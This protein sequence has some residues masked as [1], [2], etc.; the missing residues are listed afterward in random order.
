MVTVLS[1]VLFRPTVI[2]AENIPTSGPLI[3][4]PTHRSNIDF[5]FS[6]FV[7]KRKV[8]FM[9][10]DSLFAVKP[11][12]WL[13]RRVGAFP[14]Q[15]GAAD[16]ESMSLAE[17][18]LKRGEALILFPEGTRQSGDTI[19]ELHDGATFIAAR[20]GASIVPIG[21]AGSEYA[22][23]GGSKRIRP[24]KIVVVVGRPIAPPASEGRVA[25]S[26]VSAMT[27]ELQRSL[28]EVFDESRRLRD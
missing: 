15:R 4:A 18:V 23:P 9:A 13:L 24:T 20:S 5:A 27:A 6:V 8:F 14:V 10:K 28:Q 19:A 7:S 3:V 17:E 12:G 11:L 16:R 21:I 25:R 1:W 22:L 26:A 2:G